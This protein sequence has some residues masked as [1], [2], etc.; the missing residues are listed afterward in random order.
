MK[1]V[2]SA[3]KKVI[4]NLYEV[5][6]AVHRPICYEI[7]FY[8][9]SIFSFYSV[10]ELKR[11]KIKINCFLCFTHRGGTYLTCGGTRQLGASK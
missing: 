8:V 1:T 3:K 4:K 11:Q 2:I 10:L 9:Y 6:F 7:L 5:P